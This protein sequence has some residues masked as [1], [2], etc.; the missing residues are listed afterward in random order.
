MNRLVQ[1][2]IDS[3][4]THWEHFPVYDPQEV[5]F[6]LK[7]FRFDCGS[8]RNLKMAFGIVLQDGQKRHT[9]RR[10]LNERKP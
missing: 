1:I 5:V 2:E 4:E 6:Q 8:Q 3:D 9:A 7:C 10:V